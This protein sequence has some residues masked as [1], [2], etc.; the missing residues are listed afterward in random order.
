[1][2]DCENVKDSEISVTEEE[3]LKK[4]DYLYLEALKRR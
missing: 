2:I 1:M 3:R 4:F